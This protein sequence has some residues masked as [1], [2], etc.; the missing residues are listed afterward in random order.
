M[1]HKV[2]KLSASIARGGMRFITE[3]RCGDFTLRRIVFLIGL[4]VI[5]DGRINLGR[6]LAP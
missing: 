2:N 1:L 4:A 5:S 6:A 3:G